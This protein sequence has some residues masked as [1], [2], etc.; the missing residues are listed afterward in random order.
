MN[1][2]NPFP[3]QLSNALFGRVTGRIRADLDRAAL[4]AVT[5]RQSDVTLAANG[6]NGQVARIMRIADAQEAAATRLAL[7]TGRFEQAG[8][9]L[10]NLRA[11]ADDVRTAA[12][13]AADAGTGA[14]ANVAGVARETIAGAL[15]ALN[16]SF[17]GRRLFAGASGDAP[18]VATADVLT[19]ATTAATAGATT[20]ADKRAALDAYFAPG[21]GFDTDIYLGEGADA[22]P[23]RLPNGTRLSALPRADT[24]GVRNLLKGLTI[25]AQ[26]TELPPMAMADWVRQGAD[27]IR[28]GSEAVVAEEAKIGTSLSRLDTAR[29]T[30]ADERLTAESAL[31][32]IVGRDAFEAASETQNLETRLQAAYTLTSRL[33]QLSLTSFLR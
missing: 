30:L 14:I 2:I 17:D 22:A 9:A 12:L 8:A 23:L 20:P 1:G 27:L 18:A 25:L 13:T 7:G 6:R 21:G 3:D 4:E 24:E 32:R 5:G 16:T 26:S 29:E 28:A 31:D 10:R 11:S 15:G 33:T 19:A